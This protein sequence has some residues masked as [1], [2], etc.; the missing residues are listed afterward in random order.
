MNM[1]LSR[2]AQII[3][4]GDALIT[5]LSASVSPYDAIFIK[6]G[7]FEGCLEF[8]LTVNDPLLYDAFLSESVSNFGDIA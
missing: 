1:V 2:H 6:F 4:R 7:F 3:E 5:F 8:H